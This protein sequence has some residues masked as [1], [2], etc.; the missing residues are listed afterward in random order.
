M[1]SMD[2]MDPT[3]KCRPGEARKPSP[4]KKLPMP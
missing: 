4:T 3:V 2:L 1:P